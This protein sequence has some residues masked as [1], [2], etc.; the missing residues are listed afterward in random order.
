VV[1]YQPPRSYRSSPFA[2][3]FTSPSN[4]A[5]LKLTMLIRIPF[6]SVITTSHLNLCSMAIARQR[7]RGC[8]LDWDSYSLGKPTAHSNDRESHFAPRNGY[9]S[10][11]MFRTSTSRTVPQS[12]GSTKQIGRIVAILSYDYSRPSALPGR[13]Q[14]V[15][16]TCASAAMCV[17]RVR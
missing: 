10:L 9:R 8:R 13:N 2:G 7:A 12:L 16:C 1:R 17:F 14:K 15:H 11:G 6:S 5:N 3:A 4:F